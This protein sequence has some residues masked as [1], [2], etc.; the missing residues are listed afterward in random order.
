MS[1]RLK[2]LLAALAYLSI[3]VAV[4]LFT[5]Q[6]EHELSDLAISIYDNVVKGVDYTHKTQTGFVRFADA[7]K[8]PTAPPIDDE[9][10]AQL[11]TVIDNLDVAIEGAMTEKTRDK[12]KAVRARISELHD[13]PTGAAIKVD[14]DELDKDIGK[15]VGKYN[16]D[17]LTYRVRADDLVAENEK[18]LMIAMGIAVGIALVITVLLARA[19]IPPL[20]RSLAVAMAISEGRLDNEIKAKGR[21]ETSKL[22]S[23]LS[24]MQTSIVENIRRIEEQNKNTEKQAE[25]D[26]KRKTALEMM[27]QRFEM[28][29]GDLLQAVS[30]AAGTMKSSAEAMVSDVSKTNGNLQQTIAATSDATSNVATVAAAAE[31]LTASINE[32]SQQ[33]AR[34]A[35]ITQGA[36]QKAQAAD[37][38]IK[39]LSQSAEKINE[40]VGVIGNI[41][42]QINLLALNATIESARAGEAGKGFAVVASEVKTLANQTSKATDEISKQIGDITNVINAVVAALTDIQTTI[43]EMGGISST[44]ASAMEEQ[45]AATKEIARNIQMTSSKVQE[46]SANIGEVGSMSNATSENSRNVLESVNS[47]SNQSQ[48]LNN[49]IE[50]F[51]KNIAAN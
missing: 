8:G 23:A 7:H 11:G 36:V 12:A 40:I 25:T 47:F 9:A 49:E 44:I 28:Q 43:N 26:K 5:R 2:L 37:S 3:T 34:S 4:G 39:Q 42:G 14:L 16:D 30:Q 18:R 22:L 13:L 32:I 51:L 1:I 17:G 33:I 46:V 31:E 20:K 10:K 38:T 29:V 21:S 15:L 19:I 45:G 6:Q 24:T 41:A 48:T 35:S 50:E 27:A